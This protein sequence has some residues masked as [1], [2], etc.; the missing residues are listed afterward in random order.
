[1]T[2]FKNKCP[3][4]IRYIIDFD[5]NFKFT[6]LE[7]NNIKFNHPVS[8][9]YLKINDLSINLLISLKWI[10]WA[11]FFFESLSKDIKDEFYNYQLQELIPK[12]IQQIINWKEEEHVLLIDNYSINNESSLNELLEN[13]YNS[14]IFNANTKIHVKLK[15]NLREY[16]IISNVLFPTLYKEK[17]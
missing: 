13:I 3:I 2:K 11:Y 16:L 7:D 10:K 14:D 1:M 5:R 8:D 15:L 17:I 12:S 6:F 9:Y 4:Y